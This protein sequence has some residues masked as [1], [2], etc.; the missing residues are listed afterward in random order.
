[1]IRRSVGPRALL[2]AVFATALAATVAPAWA[3]DTVSWNGTRALELMERARRERSAYAVD[4][5]LHAYQAD[6]KGYVYFFVDRP[7]SD[8][9]NLVKA[10]QI[11]VRVFWEAPN[12]THQAI[13]GLR[14]K[15]VLPT[16]IHY[17]LDHLT[18]VQDDFGDRIRIGD[19]DE[20]AE[21]I[22]PAAP[23]SDK[24]Y[25]FR[26]ADS[27]SIR[28]GGSQDEVRVYEVRVRPKDPDR[29][30]FVGSVYLDRSSAAIVR[31]SF[32]FTPASYVDPYLDY[33]RISLDN[34]LWMG[35]HW[36]PYHQEVE[37]RREMPALDFQVGSII[38]GRW[39][40]G[41]YVFNPQLSPLL[42]A[43]PR[44]TAAPEAQREAYPFKRGLFDDLEEEGL[45]PTPSLEQIRAE[46]RRI[47]GARAL[48]GLRPLRLHWKS[49]SDA[50]RYNRAEGLHMGAGVDLRPDPDVRLRLSGGYAFGPDRPSWSATAQGAPEPITPELR[51][52]WNE[53]RDMGPISG[54]SPTVRSLGAAF[55]QGDWLDPYFARGASV[56][57]RG[58]R[59][60]AGPS[61]TLRW[62]QHLSGRNVLDDADFP[63][64]RPVEEGIMGAV[65]AQV[66]FGLPRGGSARTRLTVGRIE[67]RSFGSGLLQAT[68]L[69]DQPDRAW[70]WRVDGALGLASPEAPVQEL[71]LLGGRST[72]PGYGWREFVGRG[73]WLARVEGTHPLL[74]PWV[75]IRA[76]AALG[77]TTLLHASLP[78]TGWTDA[79]DTGGPLASVGA[80]LSLGWDVLRLDLARGLGEGG[81]WELIF[82][83]DPRFRPWL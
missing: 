73:F 34:A 75:G 15:K 76:F 63:P 46:A 8:E 56:T 30:G 45:A 79:H 58:P 49:A 52:Y 40:I 43:G 57:L 3:Q 78:T 17:H 51:G 29:P 47:V 42:F 20:V 2:I 72:L 38:R 31:M 61:L 55:G 48:S 69:V 74:Q 71:F 14:D 50:L 32:T 35:K 59:P 10:D 81:Q 5:G 13:V 36:L 54:V 64:V 80:G 66:P 37:L 9:R 77:A 4:A 23:G 21:V 65:D 83:V 28:F 11:A 1:M 26:L 62:E 16:N 12:R 68:W 44:V 18:V 67:D 24:A 22:H 25:D 41:S 82:S 39:E 60:D 33:I 6:A 7:D 19:G 27:L 70:K 53:L